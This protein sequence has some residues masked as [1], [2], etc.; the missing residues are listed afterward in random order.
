M[1][2][3]PKL[4]VHTSYGMWP[5]PYICLRSLPTANVP[6]MYG[7]VTSFTGSEDFRDR[8]RKVY[9]RTDDYTCCTYVIVVGALYYLFQDLAY[10]SDDEGRRAKYTEYCEI[11]RTNIETA[12]GNLPMFLPAHCE[13]VEALH[14]GVSSPAPYFRGVDYGPSP[15]P[16]NPLIP[17]LTLY[18]RRYMPL[19]SR[20]HPSRGN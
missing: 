15:A 18:R 20:D 10:T 5:G 8:C 16:F 13:T 7:Y 11:C 17:G 6:S 12:L 1:S 14:I 3:V 9:F 4:P 19:K 2:A